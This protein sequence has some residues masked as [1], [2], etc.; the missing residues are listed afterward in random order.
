MLP[1]QNSGG[2]VK[3]VVKKVT[4]RVYALFNQKIL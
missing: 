1:S 4:V 3:K 2:L